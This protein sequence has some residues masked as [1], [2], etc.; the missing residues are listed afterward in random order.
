L[1]QDARIADRKLDVEFHP[2]TILGACNPK[3]VRAAVTARRSSVP[4]QVS[5]ALG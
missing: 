1:T 5:R 4:G 3:F 2:Y